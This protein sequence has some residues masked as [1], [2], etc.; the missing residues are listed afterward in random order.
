MAGHSVEVTACLC[1]QTQ[2]FLVEGSSK[3]KN[4]SLPHIIN[5]IQGSGYYWQ[6][7]LHLSGY[8][9]V[10]LL[11]MYIGS[12][13]KRK[14]IIK[15]T[16]ITGSPYSGLSGEESGPRGCGF[17]MAAF[18]LATGRVNTQKHD[19]CNHAAW[20]ELSWRQ[21]SIHSTEK[22]QEPVVHEKEVSHCV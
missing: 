17:L 3:H 12:F 10:S 22:R 5:P 9:F 6:V 4:G 1:L 18:L 13:G 7:K 20:R 15:N 11:T 21:T 8:L 2:S 16:S 19:S 14:G